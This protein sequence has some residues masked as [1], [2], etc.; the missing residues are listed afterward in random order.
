MVLCGVTATSVSKQFLSFLSLIILFGLF[1]RMSVLVLYPLILQYCLYLHI[2][3]QSYV[4]VSTYHH[5]QLNT[6]IFIVVGYGQLYISV[7]LLLLTTILLYL[8]MF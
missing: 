8:L 7:H 4:Y 2:H 1:A 5:H 3:T 6:K